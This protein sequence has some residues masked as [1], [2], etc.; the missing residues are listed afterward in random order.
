MRYAA[1]R[2]LR[3]SR[4]IQMLRI[5]MPVLA[6]PKSEATST[7]QRQFCG[8]LQSTL[9]RVEAKPFDPSNVLVGTGVLH[10]AIRAPDSEHVFD[11]R[12]RCRGHRW[13]RLTSHEALAKLN[14]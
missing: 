12:H 8:F 3:G 6:I 11:G 4:L 5:G 1:K 14:T 2:M 10:A 13:R 9:V 7:F